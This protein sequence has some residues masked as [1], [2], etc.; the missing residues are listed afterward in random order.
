MERRAREMDRALSY[1]V[2]KDNKPPARRIRPV[3][4]GFSL[5]DTDVL[6]EEEPL[7]PPATR[8]AALRLG[9]KHGF[10]EMHARQVARLALLIFD[11]TRRIHNL[12][13]RDRELLLAAGLLHDIGATVSYKKHHKHSRDIILRSGVQGFPEGEVRVIATVARYHRKKTP[14]TDHGLFRRLT[15]ADQDRVKRLS[16]IL[17]IADGLDRS[18]TNAVSDIKVESRDRKLLFNLQGGSDML[19]ET[20][21]FNKKSH[22][23]S[24]LFNV[25]LSCTV[26]RMER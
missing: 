4:G 5:E 8:E 19:L 20:R 15:T 13:E 2:L 18:Y 24:I 1:N 14:S 25:T 17:R 7:I 21:A 3:K 23:F 26:E 22:Y 11:Q 6:R 16:A 9:R 10:E 12:Q